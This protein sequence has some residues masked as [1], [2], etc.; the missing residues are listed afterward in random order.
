MNIIF[1]YGGWRGHTPGDSC[2]LFANVLDKKGHSVEITNDLS[3]FENYEALVNKD[4]IVHCVTQEK[5]TLKAE[6]SLLEVIATGVGFAGWHGG[7]LD[8]YRESTKYQLMVGGQWVDHPGDILSTVDI[9]IS[10]YPHRILDGCTDFTLVNT[11]KYW[12]HYDP[13][14]T[15]LTHSL[16]EVDSNTNTVCMPSAWIK[17]W[18][19]GRVFACTWG[20]TYRDFDDFNSRNVVVNAIEWCAEK[21][22]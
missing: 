21:Y 1:V 20:H 18:G 5:L 7:I 10:G 2:R 4:V 22:S 16:F 3:I 19:K 12:L 6:K 8:S 14:V 11:E 15:I 17:K 13:T 9:K